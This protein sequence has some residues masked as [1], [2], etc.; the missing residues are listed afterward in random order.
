M[1]VA[2]YSG[3]SGMSAHQTKLNVIGNN[4]ANVNT[5]GFKSSRVT[6]SDVFYQN[7]Q[8]A[9]APTTNSGGINSNQLGYGAKV[10]SIDV[11]N[12]MSGGADTGRTLDVYINGEGYLQVK[13]NDG[14][15]KYTRVG[16]LKFDA[17]GNLTDAN[18]SY[19]QGFDS[20]DPA[21]TP[22]VADPTKDLINIKIPDAI[23]ATTPATLAQYSGITIGSS[24]EITGIDDTGTPKTIGY[25]AVAKFDN[26]DGLSQHGSGYSIQSTNSGK[27]ILSTPG[28]AATGTIRSGA[29]EMSNVDLSKEFTDMIIAQRGFQA[30]SRM[31]TVSDTILEELINLKR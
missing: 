5:Y 10:G 8:G 11:I 3:I 26:V 20:V 16:N 2:M 14:I 24:G 13:G 6:F 30:N 12:T 17:A 19:I 1:L 27:P 28:T 15:P 4:I 7:L 21:A 18:G 23:P 25:L 22:L 31:I 29:L 9:S